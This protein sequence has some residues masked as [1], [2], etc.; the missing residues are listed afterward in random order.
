M[1]LENYA[2]RTL[3]LP[4]YKNYLVFE[5]IVIRILA[6]KKKKKAGDFFFFLTTLDANRKW[7]VKSVHFPRRGHSPMP[8]SNVRELH[9]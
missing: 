4:G 8:A 6:G 1:G 9:E 5:E 2:K 7:L 3:D